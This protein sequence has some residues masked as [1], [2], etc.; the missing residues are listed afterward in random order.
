VA[1]YTSLCRKVGAQRSVSPD[2]RLGRPNEILRQMSAICQSI[3]DPVNKMKWRVS[4]KVSRYLPG[5]ASRTPA[6]HP[7]LIDPVSLYLARLHKLLAMSYSS[8]P[9][10]SDIVAKVVLHWWSKILRAADAIFM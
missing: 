6:D 1:S 2:A 7:T 8:R 10:Y 4:S 3:F 5:A 9:L